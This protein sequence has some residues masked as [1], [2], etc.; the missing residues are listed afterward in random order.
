MLRTLLALALVGA[1]QIAHAAEPAD[2]PVQDFVRHPTYSSVRISP[3]GDYLAMT[4]DREGQDVLV[5]MRTKDLGIVKVNTLP[6]EKSVSQFHWVS[7]TRLMFSSI[8]KFGRFAQPFGTGEWYSVNADGSMPRVLNFA[9][10]DA[11]PTQA[12]F[13]LLDNPQNEDG[14]ILMTMS[15]PRS[16][17]GV[18][19]EVVQVDTT[20][21]RWTSIGRAP[22]E[23][24]EMALDKDKAV[25]YAV[26]YDD[27]D[28]QG[29]YDQSNELYRRGDD[30]KWTL[31]NSSKSSGKMLSVMGT[32][33]DGRIYATQSDGKAPEAFG[34]IDSATGE[35]KSLFQDPVSEPSTYITSADRETVLAVVTAAGKPKITV[36][37]DEH[38]DTAVYASLAEAFPDSFVNFSSATRDGKQIVVSVS[39]DRNPGDLY[40]YDRA[41]GK[42]RFLMRNR[43][44]IDSKRMGTVKP[45]S[46]TTRDGLKVHGYLTIPNGSDGKNLPMIVNVHGG[47]IGPRDDW[48]FN[49]ETQLFASRGY[50]VLQVNYRGSGGFGKAFSDKGYGT[51]ATDIMNDIIDATKWTI[52]QGY[53]DKDRIC[54]YGG[55][56]GG[57]ASMMAP[58]REPGMFKCAFGYVGAYDAEI[59]MTK[60]DTSESEGGRRYMLRALGKTKEE[61]AAMSPV[62]H[63]AKIK[64]PVYLAAGARDARCPPENTEAM[65]KALI[66]AG[67]PPEGMIIQSG[68]MHG[69]YKEE[70]NLKLYTEMLNFFARHIRGRPA[71]TAPAT[72]SK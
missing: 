35:F 51:W 54:I 38:P 59:Q 18:N 6:D 72:A 7:P 20:S 3:N 69:F 50:A 1:S 58:A 71:G 47:P 32:S 30:G 37:E 45:I 53:A 5:V 19:T 34:V 56:F 4:V 48:G 41:T 65:Q 21:G 66:N 63:A 31:I 62:N 49:W 33:G 16:S 26:C 11:T 61:R 13:S 27:E 36:I 23:N 46:L 29:N 9:K 68:E 22:R 40:L 25:R 42:A 67:N 39:S 15:Y 55:S 14:K 70:N 60:S 52:Q 8:R 17:E 2:I 12:R 28:A 43:Q 64:I 10:R 44:W 24:C 57:Y